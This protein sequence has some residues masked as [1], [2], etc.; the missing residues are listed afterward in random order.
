MIPTIYKCIDNF[1]TVQINLKSMVNM[2]FLIKPL[3]AKVI[4]CPRIASERCCK[5]SLRN[6]S[7]T[8]SQLRETISASNSASQLKHEIATAHHRG[9]LDDLLPA[10]IRIPDGDLVE[11]RCMLGLSW[12]KTRTLKKWLKERKVKTQAEKN[13]RAIETQIVGNNLSAEW[14]PLQFTDE[15]TK[16]IVIK[17]T[18]MVA[19][20]HLEL[21]AFQQLD[22]YERQNLL[23]FEK[24]SG[25]VWLKLGGDKGGSTFKLM[26]QIANVSRPNSLRNTI[27]VAIFKATDNTY[28]L[29]LVLQKFSIEVDKLAAKTWRGR[30]IRIFHFGDYEYLTRMYGLTGPN[31]RHPCLYC[32][33]SKRDMAIPLAQRGPSPSRS[34]PNLHEQLKK[35]E[36]TPQA[37]A[38]DYMNVI[39]PPILNIPID[40]VCPPGLHITLGL[41]LKHFQSLERSCETL[42][43][44]AASHLAR[45]EQPTEQQLS[46]SMAALVQREKMLGVLKEMEAERTDLAEQLACFLLLY[47]EESTSQPVALLQE[48]VREKDAEIKKANDDLMK[49]P[50]EN[51]GSGEITAS[52]DEALHEMTIHRQAYYGRTFVGN[53]AHKCLQPSNVGKL[54]RKIVATTER[55]CPGASAV[56]GEAERVAKRYETLLLLYSRCHSRMN[57]S[58]FLEQEEID[59]L[60]ND[61]KAYTTFFRANFPSES[62]PPKLH[63]LEEHVVPWLRK[64][65]AS[66]GMMGEQG[67][68]SVHAQL[69]NIERDLRGFSNDLDILLRSIKG[70]WLACNPVAYAKDN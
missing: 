62:T 17:K 39:R 56:I 61:I 37:K 66:P 41:F 55:V 68:E 2:F 14:M 31:G 45:R 70:Q 43:R 1:G 6:R 52:L 29:S 3:V 51:K 23:T 19:V 21:K 35:F 28:N 63:L 15:D 46:K 11:V 44:V 65:G 20:K 53:H 34:L 50:K 33:I 49:Q 22:E 25:E 10:T 27:V 12:K 36:E 32:E 7:S 57:T 67:G 40:Q 69:N 47:P 42:D 5:A 8:I 16:E 38:K 48:A 26:M 59:E 18:A 60:E 4:P 13:V 64:W 9:K 24:T 54:T 30:P 58:R